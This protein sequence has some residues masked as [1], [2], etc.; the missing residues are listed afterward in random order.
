MDVRTLLEDI[1]DPLG[2]SLGGIGSGKG[3]GK[4]LR[5]GIAKDPNFVPD[6]P[7]FVNGRAKNRPIYPTVPFRMEPHP[8]IDP[9]SEYADRFE[10]LSVK[11]I[12]VPHLDTQNGKLK[13]SYVHDQYLRDVEG[14]AQN[15]VSQAQENYLRDAEDLPWKQDIAMRDK[16]FT[17]RTQT[18]NPNIGS[19]YNSKTQEAVFS[20]YQA[21]LF[22][23]G[24]KYNG[25]PAGK[26]SL[27]F[28]ESVMHEI[29]HAMTYD[30]SGSSDA[31]N[32]KEARRMERDFEGPNQGRDMDGQA[33]KRPY[34]YAS[35]EEYKVGSLI[36]LNKSR[37]L[38]GKKLM[39]PQEIH[40]L[41]DEI[42]KDPSILDKNYTIE[43]ARLPRTYL[44]LKE[45]HPEGAEILRNA[46][47]RDS[48][49]LA[50]R[51]QER[52]ATTRGVAQ[53]SGP[54]N[55]DPSLA[56]VMS[57]LEDSNNNSSL[58]D[59][60]GSA[61][62]KLRQRLSE[63]VESWLA[64]LDFGSSNKSQSTPRKSEVD[65]FPQIV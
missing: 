64:N 41:F 16:E 30:P 48:Q 37:Q 56:G 19:H 49:Y 23:N 38:T 4:A 36:F 54:A 52:S 15:L 39:N 45:V 59:I 46:T 18:G 65:N 57:V 61:V 55:V 7:F 24:R 53:L 3:A 13:P 12:E 6:S 58:K 62:A 27:S 47:A 63:P 50:L 26:E 42:E 43:E 33:M 32:F 25:F 8:K 21:T 34:F 17:F 44:M 20:P 9:D 2:V 29:S 60:G 35:S 10:S 22:A 11:N 40:Q 31:Y 5:G 1:F 51:G 28:Y 14:G